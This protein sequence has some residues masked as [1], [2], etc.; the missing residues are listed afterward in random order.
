MPITEEVFE[1]D[2]VFSSWKEI[3]TY[4]GKGVRTVQRWE[5]TLGLPVHRPAERGVILA[6]QS[7]LDAWAH[8]P[9]HEADAGAEVAQAPAAL[10]PRSRYLEIRRQS[11]AL[12]ES[13][14]K[15]I[16]ALKVTCQR[17][18]LIGSSIGKASPQS[19]QAH[20]AAAQ[21]KRQHSN[22]ATRREMAR[23]A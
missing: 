2:R 21:S 19:E 22:G 17:S 11:F 6:Y 4:L 10:D 5:R 9:Q 16:E 12:R 13:A 1:M 15:R 18:A 7:E 3:A 23:S 8:K 14:I 20:F